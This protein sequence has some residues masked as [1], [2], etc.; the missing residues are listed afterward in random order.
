MSAGKK[1][2]FVIMPFSETT[3]KHTEEYWTEH[4]EDFLKPLIE[5]CPPLE[6][7]RSKP[8]HG[9][10][11]KDIITKLIISPLLVADLTDLNPNVFW[12][13]GVRQ[14][15]K[16][17]TITIAQEGTE[18]PFDIFSKGTLFYYPENY[19]KN[20]KFCSDL[21]AALANCL[22]GTV[23]ADSS[24]LDTISG[25]GTLYEI[26]HQSEALRRLDGLEQEGKWN[27]GLLA[28]TLETVKK[29]KENPKEGKIVTLRFHSA[30][31]ELLLTER[32]LDED[33]SFYDKI[34][35]NFLCIQQL[36]DQ[37]REW[38]SAGESTEKWLE[39]N[40]TESQKCFE[41][42]S[43]AI[44]EARKELMERNPNLAI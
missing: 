25:R 3:E 1:L 4:F 24:V 2:C 34:A 21:K 28:K 19:V 37:L 15:F 43:K 32:Y 10:I 42:D 41:N 9:D 14:S 23:I 20:A 26:V 29:N 6:A 36:N 30:C 22:S 5:E 12:E 33:E 35:V 11:L 38:V 31:T 40:A 39:D 44:A 13:L 18:L 17:R 16:H 7:H 8:L 27:I